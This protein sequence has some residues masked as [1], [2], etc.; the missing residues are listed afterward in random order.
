MIQLATGCREIQTR[1]R[2]G[3]CRWS[4]IQLWWV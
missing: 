4:R 1:S 3:W 2:T